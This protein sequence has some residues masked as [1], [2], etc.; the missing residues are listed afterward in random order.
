MAG[1]FIR[2]AKWVFGGQILRLAG[3]FLLGTYVARVLGPAQFGVI[4]TAAA[5][6][7]IAYCAVELGLRQLAM[8]EIARR[9]RAAALIAGTTFRLWL[10]LGMGGASLL[11]LWNAWSGSLPWLV[12]GSV[13]APLL[14]TAFSLH[15]NWEEA[16]QRADITARF[17]LA[18]YLMA[19]VARLVVVIW[20][21][22]LEMIAWSFALEPF[23]AYGLA[24]RHSQRSG[25]HWW[26]PG[27]S[28]RVA[29]AMLTRGV[30]LMVAQT[31]TLLLLRAD[32]LMIE[33]LSGKGEAGIYGAAVRFSELG[34]FAAPLLVTL[35]QPRLSLLLK[36]DQLTNFRVLASRGAELVMIIALGTALVLWCVGPLLISL[37]LGPAYAAAA[38]VLLVH[39]LSA[40]PYFQSEWRH[41]VL[42]TMDRAGLTAGLA[43]MALVLNVTLNL[44]WIPKYGALGAA[45][46]TLICYTVCGMVGTWFV[47]DLRWLARAQWVSMFAPIRCALSPRAYTQGWRSLLTQSSAAKV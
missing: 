38:P 10:M 32:T 19:C 18:G 3:G 6:G 17:N 7:A 2:S 44:F 37:L 25:R 22:S 14:I 45:W 42:V 36:P 23:V 43:W 5:A 46:A 15:N 41:A 40:I 33:R 47:S 20:C 28:T 30:V 11:V 16:L 9:K 13:A 8:R 34:Y 21:P 27:W 35:L 24:A 4:A 29:K 26:P 31:G 1:T 39:C 12:L